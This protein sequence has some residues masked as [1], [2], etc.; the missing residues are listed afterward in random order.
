MPSTKH[1]AGLV[2][3]ILACGVNT[4]AQQVTRD[5]PYAAAH[6][7]QV[8]DVYA[9][10]GAKNLPVVFWIHGGGAPAGQEVLLSNNPQRDKHDGSV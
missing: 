3:V 7:R 6:E 9:P 4:H 2:L 10:A 1:V 5:V 8:L